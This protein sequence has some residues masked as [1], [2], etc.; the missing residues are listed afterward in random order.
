[1]AYVKKYPIKPLSKDMF[2]V[3]LA[4]C[5]KPKWFDHYDKARSWSYGHTRWGYELRRMHLKQFNVLFKRFIDTGKMDLSEP[6]VGK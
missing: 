3:M 6:K 1:M 2:C 5:P 4:K